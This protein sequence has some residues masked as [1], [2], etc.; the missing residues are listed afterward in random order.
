M[1]NQHP[2]ELTVVVPAYNEEPGLAEFHRRLTTVLNKLGLSREI[3]YINDGSTDGTLQEI[4][5]FRELDKSVAIIDLSRNFG[6]EI[7]MTAGFDYS[8]GQAVIVID[9]DLQDPPELI[10]ELLNK[11]LEG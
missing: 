6:K 2:I 9:A 1:E 5:K 10:P 11:S 7:A 3:I 4:R 8:R